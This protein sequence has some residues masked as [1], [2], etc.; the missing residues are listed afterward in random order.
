[1]MTASGERPAILQAADI[2]KSYAGVHALK[3]VSFEL[4]AGQVHALI[5]ENGAR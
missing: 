5:G 4:L 3:A 2:A 1:M